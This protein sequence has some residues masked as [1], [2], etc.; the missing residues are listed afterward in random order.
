MTPTLPSIASA[1]ARAIANPPQMARIQA[2]EKLLERT[3]FL[4]SSPI[5]RLEYDFRHG[6]VRA[7]ERI[8][9]AKSNTGASLA[10]L[11]KA[12]SMAF[13]DKPGRALEE[14]RAVSAG[15]G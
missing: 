1:K 7:D 6:D 15:D 14:A 11:R 2:A 10:E 13:P 9:A 8:A 3:A 5:R 12:W 4:M